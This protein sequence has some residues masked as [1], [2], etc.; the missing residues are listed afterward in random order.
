MDNVDTVPIMAKPGQRLEPSHNT[1]LSKLAVIQREIKA[2]KSQFNQYSNFWYRKAED[3][4]ESLKPL[5]NDCVI[6]L[7]DMPVLIGDRYYIRAL[8]K[9]IDH[10]GSIDAEAYAREPAQQKGMNE[11][12]ITGSASSYARKYALN[13]LLG[14]DDTKD[15]DTPPTIPTSTPTQRK[16]DLEKIN[17]MVSTHNVEEVKQNWSTLIGLNWPYLSSDL[18][19][20]LNKMVEQ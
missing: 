13:G 16:Q 2:P 7:S 19:N 5:L 4:L 15:A 9:I 10:T 8:A 3:I 18:Q 11:S 20:E 14:I 6:T 1:I 12:Q 17:S